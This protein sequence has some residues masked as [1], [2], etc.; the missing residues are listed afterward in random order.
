VKPDLAACGHRSNGVPAKLR[1]GRVGDIWNKNA[2]FDLPGM[3][4]D[5]RH[6]PH[7]GNHRA[8]VEEASRSA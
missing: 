1:P 4:I 8:I 7:F 2:I 3:R 5:S 6:L